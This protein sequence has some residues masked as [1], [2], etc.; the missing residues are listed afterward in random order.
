[1]A[2]SHSHH[3]LALHMDWTLHAL[4]LATML[5]VLKKFLFLPPHTD[6][7]MLNIVTVWAPVTILVVDPSNRKIPFSFPD[8][9]RLPCSHLRRSNPALRLE[10]LHRL[11]H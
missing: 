5:P 7:K 8:P 10:L 4:R 9:S 6:A 3:V 2:T 1:M 11:V